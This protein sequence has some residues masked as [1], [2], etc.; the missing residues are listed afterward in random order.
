MLL[1]SS[2]SFVYFFWISE[3]SFS[4]DISN[5]SI[6]ILSSLIILFNSSFCLIILPTSKFKDS[7]SAINLFL[8]SSSFATSSLYTALAFFK[9]CI[10]EYFSLF[11]I[12]I[13]SSFVGIVSRFEISILK[14][15]GTSISNLTGFNSSQD[16]I[17]KFLS[18]IG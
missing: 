2:I 4:K 9:A 13:A 10:F 6:L 1:S 11:I 18:I 5:S 12:S 3:I 14:D 15:I 7:I 16:F 17:S 8:F